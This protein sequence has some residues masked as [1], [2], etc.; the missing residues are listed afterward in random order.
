MKHSDTGAGYR[1]DA[2][3]WALRFYEGGLGERPEDIVA[4]AKMFEAYV[5]GGD[6]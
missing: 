4:A 2:L 1:E 3:M 5:Y 6:S